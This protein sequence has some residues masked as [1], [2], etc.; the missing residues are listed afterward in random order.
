MDKNT[1]FSFVMPAYKKR[2]LYKAIDSILKQNYQ[3]F[4]LV[5]VNDA[6]PEGLEDVIQQFHDE[7]IRYEINQINIGRHDLIAN[8][9]HCIQFAKNEYV[10]LASDD[11]MF[12]TDFL[13]KASK[14][15]C[16]YPKVD[17]IRS[18][19]KKIDEHDNIL[20]YEFPMKEYMTSREYTLSY[21]KGRTISCVSNYVFKKEVLY[22]LG[23][24]ISFPHAHYSDDATVL[25]L[26]HNGIA[27]ISTNEMNFRMSKTNLSNSYDLKIVKDQLIAT[28]LYLEWFLHHAKNLD[29]IPN[30][31]FYRACYGG[32]KA[33]YLTM[34][35]NLLSK[36]PLHKIHYVIQYIVC[37]KHMFK[38]EK[39]KILFSYFI[40]RL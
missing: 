24:F 8:W 5:I 22:N 18:G 13:S 9:N 37:N 39:C 34:I 32:V 19:V 14:L 21:A 7:R 27:C 12:E 2:F 4:E 17:I 40:N 26:T 31:F 25:A 6:S 20:D 3:D 30:D 29:K 35:D 33:R 11:D 16:K 1:A 36:I 28:E 38:K 15:I 10:I 23:G